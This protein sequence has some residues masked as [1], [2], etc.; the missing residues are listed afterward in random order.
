MHAR[1]RLALLAMSTV[2]ATQRKGSRVKRGDAGA[3]DDAPD[4]IREA[5]ELYLSKE[6]GE[7]DVRRKL[8]TVTARLQ[9][10]IAASLIYRVVTIAAFVAAMVLA[11][12]YADTDGKIPLVAAAF[13]FSNLLFVPTVVSAFA[14]SA[15]DDRIATFMTNLT[16]IL[17]AFSSGVSIIAAIL[18]AVIAAVFGATPVIAHVAFVCAFASAP[19]VIL[20][21]VCAMLVS[22]RR[23]LTDD[24]VA[25]VQY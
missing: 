20:D 5:G 2:P 6:K 1:G 21:V 12:A 10:Y 14:M 16:I 25:V 9:F 23:F 3:V 7:A 24:L 13:A 11:F 17:Y 18:L 15:D 19:C 22:E 4:G 8:R